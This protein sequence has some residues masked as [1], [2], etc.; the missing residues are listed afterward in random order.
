MGVRLTAEGVSQYKDDLRSAGREARQMSQ[1]TRLAMAELGNGA[2]STRKLTTRLKGLGEQYKV[3]KNRVSLLTNSQKEFQTSLNLVEREISGTNKELK[4]SQKETNRLENNY[5]KMGEALGWNADETKEAKREWEASKEETKELATSLNDLEKESNQYTKELEKMPGKINSAKI[6]MQEK[7][8]AM[9]RLREE[10]IRNGGALGDYADRIEDTSQRVRTFS[11]GMADVGDSLTA[12][13]TVPIVAGVAATVKA[14]SDWETAFAGTRKTVD[15]VVDANGNVVYSY[16]QL[17][18][19]LRDLSKQLPATHS[20][21]AGVAETAGQLGI[22]TENVTSFTRTMIDMGEATNLSAD[23]A[24][25]SLARLANITGMPQTEFDRLGSSIVDLGNNFATTE[26]EITQM[27]LRL[28]GTGNQIGMTESDIMGLAAAM[29]SVGIQAEAGGTA[30]ST[31]LKNM[32]NAVADGS[33]EL[34][35][36]AEVSRMSASE[37]ADAFEEDP[38]R[39][40]QAFVEGLEQSSDEGENLNSILGDLGITGIREADTLLRL[41]GNSELLG[42]A[43]DQSSGAW[44]ENSAL[45]EEAQTRY[46]TLES[47]LGILRNEV[48]DIAIEFGGP[49]VEALRDGIQAAR[50]M[51]DT[52][53]DMAQ[54][55]SD[56][57]EEQQQTIIKLIGITAAAGPALSILG[58]VGQ[59]AATAG[60]GLAWLVRKVGGLQA[61]AETANPVVSEAGDVIEGVGTT[62]AT[63]GG[64][65]GVGS[66]VTALGTSLPWAL[67]IAAAAAGGWAVWELWGEEAWEASQRTKRWGTDVSEETDKVLTDM[68]EATSEIGEQYHGMSIGIEEDTDSMAESFTALGDTVRTELTERIE[69]FGQI[70]EEYSDILS[71][72]T[73]EMLE[74]EQ[75]GI[76][77]SLDAI[78]GYVER[79]SEIRKKESESSVDMSA[80]TAQQLADLSK[81][82]AEEY[83]K[84]LGGTQE[85]QERILSALTGDIDNATQEQARTWAQSLGEQRQELVLHSQEI[86]QVA[87]EVI[88]NLELDPDGELANQIRQDFEGINQETI[89]GLDAQLA[90]IAEKYPE[91]ADEI[92]FANGEIASESTK[93]GDAVADANQK[94]I[95]NG[96]IM[97][98]ALRESALETAESQSW[99]A[100]EATSGAETWNNLVY[101][102]KQGDF[103]TDLPELVNEAAEDSVTWNNLRFQLHDANLNSNAKQ[104]IGEAAI[105]NGWWD[106]MAWEDKE[107]VLQDEFSISIYEALE[108]SGEWQEMELE[109]KTAVMYSNTPEKMTETLAYLGL[110]DEYET[111]IKEVNADNYDFI[112]TIRESEEM[113]NVWQAID[114]E[115]KELLGENYDLM[116]KIFESEERFNRFKEMP[117]EEKK[118]LAENTDLLN[119]ITQSQGVYDR[120]TSLPDDTKELIADNTDLLSTIISSEDSYNRWVNLPN[121]EKKLL[122]D[123]LNLLSTILYS[124]EEYNR[125][126][127]LPDEEKILKATT[128]TNAP[129][130]EE[131]LNQAAEAA[132]FLDQQAPNVPTSTDALT[133]DQY[134]QTAISSS[135]LLGSKSPYI[136]TSTN[137]LDTGSQ[138]DSASGSADTLNS[139]SPYIPTSTNALN[140]GGEI[141]SAS[142]SADTLNR[143]SPYI[144]TSTNANSTKGEMDTASS[145]A[146]TLDSKSPYIGTSTNAASTERA[147]SNAG[148]EAASWDGFTSWISVGINRIGDWTG[149]WSTGTQSLPKTG[150]SVLG[151]GGRREPYLTP[152]GHFGVSGNNNEL[153]HLPKGT[154]I[155]PSRQSFRT[156]ARNNDY[157]KQY[158]DHIPKFAK[159]GT[160][161]NPY[162]GYTGLVGEAGPEIFQIAQGKVSITPIS[163]N[164]RT[165][166]LAGNQVDMTETNNLLA[167]LIDLIAQG[168]VI[169]MDK[170]EVGRTIYD[171][172]D[173]IMNRNYNRR[174]VM[175]V[176]GG[177]SN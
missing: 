71:D 146:N 80:E 133:T 59:G 51:L 1:E 127:E 19:E 112:N 103:E 82:T 93:V 90:A 49:F 14:A 61:S 17:E 116:T 21:I 5:R 64:T 155:W 105:T 12:G 75:Q 107:I 24:A 92:I 79:A 119:V 88:E 135:D 2:S 66:L 139:K 100:D 87:E 95:D 169:Q 130:T 38:A 85:E 149:L 10:Y 140:T 32:Q 142:G 22:E 160:I 158:L 141:D 152:Q 132:G 144:P 172:V 73:K 62:A 124:E 9:E 117:D 43:L 153:H 31:T 18:G 13:V 125:W 166:A 35:L 25:T 84:T 115:T 58:R 83:I 81:A 60:D 174:D 109:E 78:N 150:F 39:A 94:I 26:A 46:E 37:F 6:S 102:A 113:M 16:E 156:S 77:E 41:A 33:E 114:P 121:D 56:L 91:I 48:M 151:D 131:Y 53:S 162:D 163:Q 118:L 86:E 28:A 67:G 138:M 165:Q 8:N 47:Q 145:S 154:R 42:E 27:G 65:K 120:W 111:E 123:N 171:E 168:Q 170:K 167:T 106:G 55:F 101:E 45:A 147:I 89:N 176:K 110:W 134:L 57:D 126:R 173:S 36:F 137:A 108:R 98:N 20:E 72:N 177:G 96:R 122:G 175:S 161:Q 136:P 7:A 143:K 164:Q 34:E 128:R 15:E 23:E 99:M 3:Q 54:G 129:V 52:L 70:S 148:N 11:E 29:S 50:P 74:N 68:S 97:S 157:L 69:E 76:Q 4:A 44:E 63:A 159:G 104:I 30:M 40:L